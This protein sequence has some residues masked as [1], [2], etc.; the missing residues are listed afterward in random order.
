MASTF[1]LRVLPKVLDDV[2]DDVRHGGLLDGGRAVHL[3]C[4][5]VQQVGL[6][7]VLPVPQVDLVAAGNVVDHALDQFY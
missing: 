5:R 2:P 3:P 7:H 6:L 1:L 4:R